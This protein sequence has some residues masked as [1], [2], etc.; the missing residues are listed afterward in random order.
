MHRGGLSTRPVIPK[1]TDFRCRKQETGV[2]VRRDR[3][4]LVRVGSEICRKKINVF[5]FFLLVEDKN[6]EPKKNSFLIL[7]F[8]CPR[9]LPI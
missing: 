6:E 5:L 1:P 7:Y 2:E 4:I 3:E 9:R 8:P